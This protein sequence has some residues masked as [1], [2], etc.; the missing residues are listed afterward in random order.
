VDRSTRG[1]VSCG[2][3]LQ[4]GRWPAVQS[5]PPTEGEYTPMSGEAVNLREAARLTGWS[6]KTLRRRCV[7]GQI[8]GA[9]KLSVGSG[10]PEWVIPSES[11]P[12]RQGI[13]REGVS[14]QGGFRASQMA[15]VGK[16]DG[17]GVAALAAVITDLSSRLSEAQ[18]EIVRLTGEAAEARGQLLQLQA[19]ESG[20]LLKGVRRRLGL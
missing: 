1:G 10:E 15:K 16:S 20:S 3:G 9:Q 12:H 8:A 14:V 2:Y 5:R 18:S 13:D 19:G 7:A 17:Q 11:L 6:V 4:V